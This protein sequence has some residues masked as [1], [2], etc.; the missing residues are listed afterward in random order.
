[1]KLVHTLNHV[2][3]LHTQFQYIQFR[4]SLRFPISNTLNNIH[5]MVQK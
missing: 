3:N 4:F 2:Y 1:M 5:V